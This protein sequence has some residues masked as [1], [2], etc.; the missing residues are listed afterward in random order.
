MS[1]TSF[2]GSSP[3]QDIAVF[4][5]VEINLEYN[6]S[7]K[8]GRFSELPA[9]IRQA[10]QAAFSKHDFSNCN[11]AFFLDMT[12]H[13]GNNQTPPTPLLKSVNLVEIEVSNGRL[14]IGGVKL[15]NQEELRL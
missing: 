9:D 13:D 8:V 14:I 4:P 3:R 2:D 1:F 15:K 6:Q 5:E 12:Y 7:M 10:A 11:F